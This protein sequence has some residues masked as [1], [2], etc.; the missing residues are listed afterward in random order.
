MADF[1]NGLE[2][3]EK[4]RNFQSGQAMFGAASCAR[5]HQM[6]NAGGLIGPDLTSVGRRF[7][8]KDILRSIIEPSAVID[9]KYRV[10]VITTRDGHIVEGTILDENDKSLTLSTNPL[11]TD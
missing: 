8:V 6:G 11:T 7:G 2:A 5:C 3:V 1:G 9:E 10:T 4:G